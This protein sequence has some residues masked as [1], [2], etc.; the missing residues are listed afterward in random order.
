M[1]YLIKCERRRKR[2]WRGWSAT[3][4]ERPSVIPNTLLLQNVILYIVGRYPVLL[5]W[6]NN[7]NRRVAGSAEPDA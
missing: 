5:I 1:I 2:S 7:I 6:Y 4:T 3:K